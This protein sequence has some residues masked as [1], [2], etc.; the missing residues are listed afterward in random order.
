ME[1]RKE[2]GLITTFVTCKLCEVVSRRAHVTVLE[3]A[4]MRRGCHITF[5]SQR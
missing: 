4:S 5:H 3:V 1:P 2:V